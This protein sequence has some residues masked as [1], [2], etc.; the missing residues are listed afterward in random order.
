MSRRNLHERLAF[1]N[2]A[3]SGVVA[4]PGHRGTVLQQPEAVYASAGDVHEELIGNL[5][6]TLVIPAP[7]DRNRWHDRHELD[8]IA[9]QIPMTGIRAQII[10]TD[11]ECIT[12]ETIGP[13]IE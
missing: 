9:E 11:A 5:G 4:S 2:I 3:L 10:T 1:G 6:L 13:I 7:S 12:G 8:L